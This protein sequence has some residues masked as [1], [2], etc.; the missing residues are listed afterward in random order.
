MSATTI[1]GMIR[2]AIDFK[3]AN[4]FW[5]AVGRT[6]T[7]WPDEK[8]PPPE[9]T[10]AADFVEIGGYQKA[11]TVSLCY[12]DPAGAIEFKGA[13]YSLVT[14]ENAYSYE[15]RFLYASTLLKFDEFPVLTFR[16]YRLLV[17]VIPTA[18]N[19]GK[20]ILLPGEVAD[21]G[22]VIGY[23]NHPPIIRTAGSKNLLEIIIEFVPQVV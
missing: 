10:N 18:G 13:R 3:N 21:R 15:S 17:G 16:Q 20:S 22:K 2:I 8:N 9:T 14:D 19:E 1:E 7:P 6:Q 5:F 4:V 23:V 11:Q 12:P